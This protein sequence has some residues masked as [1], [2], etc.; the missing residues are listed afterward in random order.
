MR[1]RF[2]TRCGRTPRRRR[3]RTSGRSAPRARPNR[4]TTIASIASRCE[5]SQVATLITT[6]AMAAAH[7][8]TTVN[9]N[10]TD[11]PNASSIPVTGSPAMRPSSTSMTGT[12]S[13]VVRMEP[14][15]NPKS[16]PPP[17]A[18]YGQPSAISRRDVAA[19]SQ[20]PQR[21]DRGHDQCD[22]GDDAAR[23]VLDRVVRVLPQRV[24]LPRRWHS[25][26]TRRP[27]C[28][29]TT[30][31]ARASG[32]RHACVADFLRCARAP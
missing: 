30:T 11:P 29:R 24:V 26:P 5:T 27:P 9:P 1:E 32:N 25:A 23:A 18:G 2:C 7:T 14:P 16:F 10:S 15:R 6:A 20:S 21:E 12:R 8:A 4:L 31:M 13:A 3:S 28:S 19:R 22:T 17:T